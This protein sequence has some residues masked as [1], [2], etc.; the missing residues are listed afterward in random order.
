VRKVALGLPGRIGAMGRVSATKATKSS[1]FESVADL[2][3][4]DRVA[5]EA[6]LYVKQ[7]T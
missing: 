5:D 6:E 2:G 7:S 4:S 1:F 3:R